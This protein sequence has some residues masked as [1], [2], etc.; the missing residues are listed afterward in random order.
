MECVS[1]LLLLRSRKG[2]VPYLLV[3]LCSAKGPRRAEGEVPPRRGHLHTVLLTNIGMYCTSQTDILRQPAASGH[4]S[5]ET[6]PLCLSPDSTCHK[7]LDATLNPVSWDHES[8][9]VWQP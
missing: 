6:T 3:I 7:S 9:A 8:L 2:T 5:T 4:Q 1:V